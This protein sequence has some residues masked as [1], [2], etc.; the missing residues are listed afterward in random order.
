MKKN[1]KA[2]AKKGLTHGGAPVV[3]STDSLLLLRRT[4]MSCFLW[5]D[6]FYEDGESIAKRI[7]RLA[8]EVAPEHVAALAIEAR[9]S[10]LRHAPLLLLVSLAKTGSGRKDGLVRTTVERVIR[11]A[12]ELSEL[13]KLYWDENG[14]DASVSGQIKKGLA[15]AF[16]KFDAYRLAKYDRPSEVKLRDVLRLAHPRPNQKNADAL[17]KLNAG[18]LESPDTWEVALSTGADKKETFERLLREEKLGYL[19]LLR[20]L[21]NMVQAKVD[22]NLIM[23]ALADGRGSDMVLPFRYMAAARACPE[24]SGPL[25]DAFQDRLRRNFR[26]PGTTLVV[27]DVS[28]S[29]H[30]PMSGKSD[31]NRMDAGGALAAVARGICEDAII[32]ATAGSDMARRH[33]TSLVPTTRGLALADAITKMSGPLGGG[34]IFLTQCMSFIRE[35]HPDVKFD[36]VIVITDEQDCSGSADQPSKAPLLGRHNYIINVAS[37]QNGI[38]H[39][40]WTTVHGFSE[41]VFKYILENER[42]K[43]MDELIQTDAQLL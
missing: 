22:R 20:N 11:R 25:D 18:T 6:T 42:A 3:V 33:K 37:Y 30:S 39:G 26:L 31:M 41:N 8:A 23:K 15:A 32:Y 5:E 35:Q 12:D 13:L 14:K 2:L 19:A 27:V 43:A 24:M 16:A 40:N 28:G 17:A 34:G 21:R 4:I 10:G 38:G 1:V 36:R 7:K 9:D 29:M